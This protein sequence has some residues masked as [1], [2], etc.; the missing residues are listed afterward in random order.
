MGDGFVNDDS[1]ISKLDFGHPLYLHASDTSNVSIVNITLKGTE[2]YTVWVNAMELALNVKNKIGFID[3]SCV[4]P[5]N[6]AL[7]RQWERCNSVVLSWILNSVAEKLYLGQ[8]FSKNAA[9]VWDELRETYNKVNGSVVYDIHKQI[10]SVSQ[11][12]LS[13]AEYYHNLNSLW[14]QYDTI[15]NLPTCNCQAA[16]VKAV[17]SIISDEESHKNTSGLGFSKSQ[18]TAFVAKTFETKKK[19]SK[20]IGLKCSHCNL[21]VHTIERCYKLV[22]YPDNY[23]KKSNM[24][25]ANNQNNNG[26]FNFSKGSN[27]SNL[28]FSPDQFAKLLN[29]YV[30]IMCY[31]GSTGSTESNFSQGW[32]ID[33]GANQHMTVSEHN[34][35]D[36]VDVSDVGLSVGHPNGDSKLECRFNESMCHVQDSRHNRIL[37]SGRQVD[38][39]YFYKDVTRDKLHGVSN[40]IMCSSSRIIH[41]TSCVNTPQ[42]NGIVERKHR[43]LLNVA[44]S[45]M[46]QGG[47][48]LYMWLEC[49]LAATYLINRTPTSVLDDTKTF[50][51]SRDVRFYE[52]VFLFKHEESVFEKTSEQSILIFFDDMIQTLNDEGQAIT[53]DSDND[54]LHSVQTTD[55]LG[56]EQPGGSV[57]PS[58][59][60]HDETSF[61]DVTGG[62]ST[63]GKAQPDVSSQRTSEDNLAISNDEPM[64]PDQARVN[65][66]LMLSQV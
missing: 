11:N 63:P 53:K 65:Q 44:R 45:L 30:N 18:A 57:T 49:V 48:P 36:C 54:V 8:F 27:S 13:L 60:N 20:T 37:M 39:L 51:F 56:N 21:T 41:Q 43:H 31:A 25:R 24:I 7:G 5:T 3:M 40:M 55:T 10:N 15:T 23:K 17:F 19:T 58:N 28:Q 59:A 46:F 6:E 16:A 4:K 47:I 1:V 32:I 14:R 22:G 62:S 66:F 33:S 64:V 38:G 52:N 35:F 34:M 12:G 2:N 29:S 42:Q 26:V 61:E 50:L 9:T